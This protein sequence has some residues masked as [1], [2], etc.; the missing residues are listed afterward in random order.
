[1]TTA[2]KCRIHAQHGTLTKA[3][4]TA[5]SR[6][7]ATAGGGTTSGRAGQLTPDSAAPARQQQPSRSSDT[8]APE[9][10]SWGQHRPSIEQRY[11]SASRCLLVLVILLL[12]GAAAESPPPKA[13]C[14]SS[15]TQHGGSATRNTA[16]RTGG[17]LGV[18][19]TCP[20]SLLNL[21]A[22][23]RLVLSGGCRTAACMYRYR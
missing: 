16:E 1:M 20:V 4:G 7:Q 21:L 12:G 2:L 18:T 9:P 11:S 22:V 6:I 17:P 3:T 14:A 10:F 19:G 5:G 13:G 8:G 15:S 23:Q